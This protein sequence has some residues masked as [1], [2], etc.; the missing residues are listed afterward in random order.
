MIPVIIKCGK[1][2]EEFVRLKGVVGDCPYCKTE[3][4][5]GKDYREIDI[6]TG[7]IKEGGEEGERDC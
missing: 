6:V 2:Q 1:C 5:S 7:E 4:K 3:Y